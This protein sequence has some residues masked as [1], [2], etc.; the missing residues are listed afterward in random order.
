MK[1]SINK[2][3]LLN[4]LSIVSKGVSARSTLPVLSGILLDASGD[5]ITMQSSDLELSVKYRVAALV[6]EEGRA[7]LPGKYFLDI[8][9][10]LP[11]AAVAIDTN[12]ES[13]HII[14]GGASFSIKILNAEDFPAF[15]VVEPDQVVELPYEEFCKMVK[16]V[17]KVVSRDETRAILTG[18]LISVNGGKVRMVATDSYRLALT[19]SELPEANVDAF[20]A[21]IAGSFLSELTTLPKGASVLTLGVAE[22]QIIVTCGDTVMINRRIEG[23]FPNYQQ[24]LPESS[25]MRATA[26]LEELK[27]S[28]RRSSLLGTSATPVKLDFNVDSQTLLITSNVLDVGHTEETLSCEITGEDEVVAFNSSYVLDGLAAINTEKVHIELIS[29]LK[30][31]I[32]RADAPENYLYLVMPVHISS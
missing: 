17:V 13:A 15:P 21:V 22:N 18:V 6:E 2:S 14:G 1:I 27:A 29:S 19:E 24:L 11:D 23:N 8:V 25:S 26:D 31:G 28:I 16:R 5:G 3:E 7:V 12:I 20:Q 10:N 30:P 9:K 32:F 4:A